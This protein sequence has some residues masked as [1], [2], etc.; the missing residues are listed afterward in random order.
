M[1]RGDPSC[2]ALAA[3]AQMIS[4]EPRTKPVHTRPIR[5]GA[6]FGRLVAEARAARQ[7][8][9]RQPRRHAARPPPRPPARRPPRP[10]PPGVSRCPGQLLP[11]LA[12]PRRPRRRPPPLGTRSHRRP[13]L[14]TCARS[15]GARATYAA[16]PSPP[17][18]PA[19]ARVS[20]PPQARPKC[21]TFVFFILLDMIAF[22]LFSFD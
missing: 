11:H 10:T 21:F 1:A 5:H 2:A 7:L 13:R 20:A 12:R 19:A 15:P 6:R 22:F 17:P 14:A 16:P 3:R 4:P 9:N 18:P 8:T